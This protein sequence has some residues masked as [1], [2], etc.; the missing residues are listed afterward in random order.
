MRQGA[1]SATASVSP[2]VFKLAGRRALALLSS[3]VLRAMSLLG[4]TQ[5]GH[6][7][8]RIGISFEET[9]VPYR[10]RTGVAAVRE[11]LFRL[12]LPNHVWHKPLISRIP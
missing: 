4:G 3:S 7:R 5:P 11:P 12:N 2:P 8:E 9:G 1:R 6:Q 10:I